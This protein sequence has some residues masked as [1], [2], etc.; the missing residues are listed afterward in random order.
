[1]LHAFRNPI[2]AFALGDLTMLVGADQSGR[3]LEVGVAMAE[4]VEF[5]VRAMVAREKFLR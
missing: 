5:I 2:R 3:M 4:G 1:M